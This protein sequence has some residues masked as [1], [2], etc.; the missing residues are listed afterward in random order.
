MRVRCTLRG[1]A[2]DGGGTWRAQLPSDVLGARGRIRVANADATVDAVL[3][4]DHAG[5]KVIPQVQFEERRLDC[6]GLDFAGLLVWRSLEDVG[7]VEPRDVLG[8]FSPCTR[9]YSIVDRQ[10]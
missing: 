9:D 8:G 10:T 4:A 5:P 1:V 3:H 7:F 6:G 2:A